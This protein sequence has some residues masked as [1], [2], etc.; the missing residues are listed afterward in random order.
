MI[1]NYEYLTLLQSRLQKD[2]L[3]GAVFLSD[4]LY[5]SHRMLLLLANVGNRIPMCIQPKQCR[6]TIPHII[7]RL[8]SVEEQV[9]GT[10]LVW[11]IH[12][13]SQMGQ[14]LSVSCI[15]I[16]NFDFRNINDR[17]F[18]L[19][20]AVLIIYHLYHPIVITQRLK[21]I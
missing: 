3:F 2:P 10:M 8:R 5:I 19:C 18:W 13:M 1:V 6:L 21:V 11:I 7:S 12:L 15:P 4:C 9:F 17:K 20:V 16:V 14:I